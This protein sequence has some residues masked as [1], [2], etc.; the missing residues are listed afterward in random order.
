MGDKETQFQP[1]F[2]TGLLITP[3]SSDSI[4]PATLQGTVGLEVEA[5][6]QLAGSVDWYAGA[7]LNTAFTTSFE[8]A[9]IMARLGLTIPNVVQGVHLRP[10]ASFK[11]QPLRNDAPTTQ[12]HL[13]HNS[14]IDWDAATP[15]I[16]GIEAIIQPLPSLFVVL[17][18]EEEYLKR[19][20][21]TPQGT[22]D[23]ISAF[24]TTF[25]LKLRVPLHSNTQPKATVCEPY[26]DEQVREG[27][28]FREAP[29]APAPAAPAPAAPA[30][31]A[32]AV[33]WVTTPPTGKTPQTQSASFTFTYDSSKLTLEKFVNTIL[34]FN[35][36]KP[37]AKARLSGVT[38]DTLDYVRTVGS[39]KGRT[40]YAMGMPR[41]SGFGP[42][43]FV[44]GMKAPV[45]LDKNGQTQVTLGWN[46]VKH[47]VDASGKVIS[48][49]YLSYLQGNNL[50]DR[51]WTVF[52]TGSH[53]LVLDPAA[54][55]GTYTYTVKIALGNNDTPPAPGPEFVCAFGK[56]LLKDT[57][58]ISD[59]SACR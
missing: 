18:A 50:A 9:E 51:V 21:Q 26:I 5:S 35:G 12:D 44:N 28:L 20:G 1:T 42:Y 24:A 17:G 47:E 46:L 32:P 54:K 8:S 38:I 10:Y 40:I 30:P 58:N 31:A 22:P 43:T 4:D 36:A 39:A 49:P 7:G 14:N 59:V 56:N 29:A 27:N 13:P 2:N 15:L 52:N 16:A 34:N 3:L 55:T 53:K 23:P 48:G 11:L 33:E 57:F 6:N 25:F 45:Y 37:F 19:N 41:I